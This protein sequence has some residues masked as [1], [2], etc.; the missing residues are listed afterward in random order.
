VSKGIDTGSHPGRQVGP[1]LSDR[2]HP[3]SA[4]SQTGPMGQVT[5]RDWRPDQ[6]I[7]MA[8]WQG[9]GGHHAEVEQRVDTSY[10]FQRGTEHNRF[11]AGPFR[12]PYRAQVAAQSL[13]NR[14]ASDPYDKDAAGTARYENDSYTEYGRRRR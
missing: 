12:T 2:W 13:A 4:G 6:N 5:A 8:A 9:P 3:I 1:H 10:G 14:A 11:V 7:D